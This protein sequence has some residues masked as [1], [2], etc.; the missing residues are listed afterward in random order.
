MKKLFNQIFFLKKSKSGAKS[1]STIYLRI[2]IDG[3]RTEISTQRQC[4]PKKWISQA[5]RV[6]G[7]TEEMRTLN[8]YLDA[9]EHRIYDI[10][11]ELIAGDMEITGEMIKSKF[12][13]I[14]ERPRIVVEIYKYHNEQVATLVGKEF[15]AGT[16]KALFKIVGS[17]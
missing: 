13:G 3:I 4:D 8:N 1:F 10:H 5:G 15:S 7:K 16:L 9:V 17:K 6:N 2:T 14:S 11:K 12:L